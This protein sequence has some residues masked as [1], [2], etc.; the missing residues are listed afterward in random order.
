MP[1]SGNHLSPPCC[2][3]RFSPGKMKRIGVLSVLLVGLLS[4]SPADAATS[5]D[6]LRLSDTSA[7]LRDLTP[8]QMDEVLWLARCIFSEADRANEQRLV[9]WVVRNRVETGYRGTDYRNVVLEAQQF[10]AFNQPSARRDEILAFNQNSTNPLWKQALS[11]ALDVYQASP[12]ERPFPISTRHFYSPVSMKNGGV[13]DWALND[14]PIDVSTYGIDS[15]RF[16]FFDNVDAALATTEAPSS[17]PRE[18]ASER[19]KEQ[20]QRVRAEKPHVRTPHLSGK[21]QRPTRP[22][23]A[24]AGW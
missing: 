23:V 13:P 1:T 24:R 8:M 3:N 22:T 9:A 16:K 17:A 12:A 15:Y 21:V 20:Q 7:R 6:S 4:V 14:T 11:I 2:N 5:V 10:S 19:I 18:S